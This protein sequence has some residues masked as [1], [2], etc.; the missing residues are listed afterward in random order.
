MKQSG[1]GKS[2]T[3]DTPKTYAEFYQV[4]NDFKTSHNLQD[5]KNYDIDKFL[6]QYGRLLI[7]EIQIQNS[8]LSLEQAKTALKK[9]L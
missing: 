7:D 1:N 9:Q 4:F 5:R 8:N 3:F 6:W 2:Y